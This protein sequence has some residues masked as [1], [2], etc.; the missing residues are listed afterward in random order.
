MLYLVC[1]PRYTRAWLLNV[2][3]LYHSSYFKL[4]WDCVRDVRSKSWSQTEFKLAAHAPLYLFELLLSSN[5]SL[6]HTE[7]WCFRLTQTR[8][9]ALHILET[10][11]ILLSLF[12]LFWGSHWQ[13]ND[14]LFYHCSSNYITT[15]TVS[16]SFGMWKQMKLW[17]ET[18][19]CIF[20]FGFK[21]QQHFYQLVYGEKM[22]LF[23]LC[24]L[25][26]YFLIFFRL[27]RQKGTRA[28]AYTR[29]LN[30]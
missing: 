4:I 7:P 12:Y 15:S 23:L 5:R 24:F 17:N 8:R 21:R 29:V 1:R 11:Y 25:I 13:K 10:T 26:H 20:V 30:R 19:R 2:F 9:D 28:R 16:V 3:L 6:M 22:Y 27:T 14:K 18:I